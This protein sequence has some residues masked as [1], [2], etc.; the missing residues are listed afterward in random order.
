MVLVLTTSWLPQKLR[1]WAEWPAYDRVTGFA[2]HSRGSLNDRRAWD[3]VADAVH[4]YAAPG[5]EIL[6]ALHENRGHFANAPIFYWYVDR[7]PGTRF[8]EFDPCLTD[9]QRVQRLIVEDISNTNVVITTT[10][11]P[12]GPPPLGRPPTALDDYLNTNF[13]VLRLVRFPQPLPVGFQ[14]TITVLV[15]NGAAPVR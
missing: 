15:R 7:P 3:A 2:A 1:A 8:I 4:D 6:V 11:F 10:F 5:E 9:T 14:Q 12:Q 13:G